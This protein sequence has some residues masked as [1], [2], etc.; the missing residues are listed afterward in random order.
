ML[1]IECT[2]APGADS[3]VVDLVGMI[4]FLIHAGRGQHLV[5]PVIVEVL[6]CPSE[7]ANLLAHVVD[8][9]FGAHLVSGKPVQAH[10][11]V[12]EDGVARTTDMERAIR[13]GGSVLDQQR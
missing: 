7:D 6:Q 2:K 9:V 4:R 10:E 8:V 12:P 1:S 13:V 5:H 3:L 11:A